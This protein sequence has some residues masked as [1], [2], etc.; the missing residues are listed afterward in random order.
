MIEKN[1]FTLGKIKS[2]TINTSDMEL[3]N[4][5]SKKKLKEEDV[6]IFSVVLCDNDIDRDYEKFSCETL[7]ELKEL[8]VG[9]TGIFDHDR[10]SKGQTGRI[11]R[12][13]LV[14]DES[15]LTADGE[16]Y[17]A[18]E[19]DVYIPK[20]QTTENIINMI[21]TGILKEVSIGCSVGKSVCG[22]CG[23]E[24]CQHIKG[25]KYGDKTCFYILNEAKDAYEFSFVAVP[26]QRNA[27]VKKSFSKEDVKRNMLERIKNLAEGEEI[28][29]SYEEVIE[30]KNRAA[31]GE[32]YREKLSKDLVK[33]GRLAQ[34]ELPLEL[35]ESIA[36]KA[37]FKELEEL[38]AVYKKMAEGKLP[39]NPQLIPKRERTQID[40]KDFKI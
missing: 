32:C 7:G 33:F 6:Y 3:I 24:I 31:W 17:L 20:T 34:P 35:L 30:L 39:I 9:K 36:K 40:N 13:R 27:G 2:L 18:L 29:L 37:D 10:K 21:E 5:Y 14:P 23:K 4:S 19:A 1:D 38:N 26:A 8:F 22:I 28:T 12:T 25:K 15:R 11:F 16:T